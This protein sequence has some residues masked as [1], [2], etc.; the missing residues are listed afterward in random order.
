MNLLFVF[1][2]VGTLVLGDNGFAC[3]GWDNVIALF[4][5]DSMIR[6]QEAKLGK[7][8]A[9]LATDVIASRPFHH[10]PLPPF[11]A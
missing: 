8:P 2:C 10:S 11:A 7:M 6:V 5:S 4:N 3:R 9:V 1:F